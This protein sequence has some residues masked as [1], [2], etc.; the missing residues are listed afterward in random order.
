MITRIIRRIHLW[1]GVLLGI[2]IMLW[3]LSGVFMT[4]Y[5]IDLVRGERN[6]PHVNPVELDTTSYASPGG[7]VAQFGTTY[8]V[9][10]THFDIRPVYKVTGPDGQALFDAKSGQRLTPFSEDQI[11]Q[12]ARK[13]FVGEGTIVKID[14]IE[15]RPTEY[16]SG[17]LPAYRVQFDDQLN[18]R[19]YISPETGEVVRRR[20][21]I[22]RT[23]D[24]F[25]MLHTMDYAGRDNFNNPLVKTASFLGLIFA[26]SGL[27]MIFFK[28]SRRMIASDVS[29]FLPGQRAANKKAGR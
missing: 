12:I 29:R 4:W 28:S 3:M 5:D 1:A 6:A 15:E 8:Q 7:I 17:T 13:S 20:N 18:S 26:V 24:F 27:A 14:P 21:D 23:F 11:R 19:L 2:Q 16:R 22:W 10:L 25:W 9:E